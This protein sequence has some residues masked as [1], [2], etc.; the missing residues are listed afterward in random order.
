MKKTQMYTT[1]IYILCV[2]IK[3][4]KNGFTYHTCRA[5]SKLIFAY[6]H[7]GNDK[8]F[9]TRNTPPHPSSFL[10]EIIG[11]VYLAEFFSFISNL[12]KK[13]NSLQILLL[14]RNVLV[15]G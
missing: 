2:A 11:M 1:E 7:V 12:M 13:A 5:I 8:L 6:N 14:L 9:T 10:V 15:R 3:D 4:W